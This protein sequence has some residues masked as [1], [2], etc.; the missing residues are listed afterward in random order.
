MFIKYQLLVLYL[1]SAQ[2]L[3]P[4][5]K[6]SHKRLY[7]L[8]FLS[9][10]CLVCPLPFLCVLL[11]S[12]YH[13]HHIW[14]ILEASRLFLLTARKKII[15][16]NA[17]QL[18]IGGVNKYPYTHTHLLIQ[19]D[20]E[21]AIHSFSRSSS[22]NRHFSI[23]FW[24]EVL[25]QSVVFVAAAAVPFPLGYGFWMEELEIIVN[26][27]N[28]WLFRRLSM[29]E[30]LSLVLGLLGGGQSRLNG[31]GRGDDFSGVWLAYPAY[32]KTIIKVTASN[33][34]FSAK[35]TTTTTWCSCV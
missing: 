4:S 33:C 18:E 28:L 24:Q 35:W 21:R 29:V 23:N 31:G 6:S 19:T 5:S 1:K 27:N 34:L 17:P 11:L 8:A 30:C 15:N 13:I 22:P 26:H 20:D 2:L 9:L 7:F 12:I 32:K 16:L 14:A 10:R 25:N 3:F